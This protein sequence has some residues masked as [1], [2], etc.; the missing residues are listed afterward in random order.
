MKRASASRKLWA[1]NVTKVGLF[2][3]NL[4]AL[5]LVYGFFKFLRG[6]IE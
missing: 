1:G 3:L 5:V 4:I 2:I 6:K